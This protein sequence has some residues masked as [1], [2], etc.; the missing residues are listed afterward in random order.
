MH[1]HRKTPAAAVKIVMRFVA[2]TFCMHSRQMKMDVMANDAMAVGNETSM[3]MRAPATVEAVQ[4]AWLHRLTTV[5]RLT[6]QFL[7][8]NCARFTPK[9]S[10]VTVAPNR[11]VSGRLTFSQ[12]RD[13]DAP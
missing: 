5:A 12:K 13:N 8:S 6:S 2:F 11:N 7:F 10:S 3:P 9:L 4:D 1:L